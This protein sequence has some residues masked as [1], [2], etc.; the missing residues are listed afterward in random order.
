MAS[1]ETKGLGGLLFALAALATLA[2]PALGRS[3][4][5]LSPFDDAGAL[6]ELHALDVAEIAAGESGISKASSP[7][8]RDYARQLVRDHRM[9][10]RTVQ[11]FAERLG[12]PIK[13]V[14]PPLTGELA[15]LE[16]AARGPGYDRAF[17]DAMATSHARAIVRLRAEAA[18]AT[19]PAM[20]RVLR[21]VVPILDQQRRLAQH[22]KE[23]IGPTS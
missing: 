10:D 18:R 17:L 1:T 4:Q 11:S 13:A 16:H 12:L 20:R 7:L 2:I 3:T 5:G 19:D 9:I 21:K 14:T 6:D 8:L 23:R 15:A 22:V